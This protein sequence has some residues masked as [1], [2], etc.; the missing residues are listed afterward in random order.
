MIAKDQTSKQRLIRWGFLFLV[1][2]VIMTNYYV[3]DAM[4]SIKETMQ[5]QLGFS[6]T[7]YGMVVSFYSFPN[8]FL[9]MAVFGGI[10]LDRFGIRKTGA[11]FTLFCAFGEAPLGA[12]GKI[13]HVSN[14]PASGSARRGTGSKADLIDSV[15]R[16]RSVC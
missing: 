16:L 2:I 6:S 5:I 9:L 3:Y 14:T 10:F 11:L 13:R 4:S 12:E 1:S 7:E 15:V 8:T